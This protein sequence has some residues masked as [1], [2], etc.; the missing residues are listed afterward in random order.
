MTYDIM[1]AVQLRL[2]W[3]L[4]KKIMNFQLLMK[5]ILWKRSSKKMVV[6][7]CYT[8]WKHISALCLKAKPPV[9]EIEKW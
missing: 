2:T 3:N 9:I 4:K 8:T 7:F 1:F 5:H 6:N